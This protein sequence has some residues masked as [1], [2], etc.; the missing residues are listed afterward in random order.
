MTI[1]LLPGISEDKAIKKPSN[2]VLKALSN[3]YIGNSGMQIG[4]EL[5]FDSSEV[6]RIQYEHRGKLIQQNKEMLRVW[7]H[8]SF[9]KPSVREL[10]KAL[11]NVGKINCV[12]EISF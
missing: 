9:P 3:Q 12:S 11:R 10:I 1:F 5:G 7:S 8:T 2:D 4:I 6:Q